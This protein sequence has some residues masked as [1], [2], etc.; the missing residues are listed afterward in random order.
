LGPLE[1]AAYPIA[2][3]LILC[4]ELQEWNREAYGIL[5]KKR[6]QAAQAKLAVTDDALDIT[7]ITREGSLPPDF[8]REKKKL[9]RRLLAL[10][11]LFGTV[12]VHCKAPNRT[13]LPQT[14]NAPAPRPSLPELEGLARAIHEL[15]N[16]K[17]LLRSPDK[18]LKYPDFDSLPDTL[19][20]SNLRQAMDIPEKLRKMGFLMG[21]T[22]APGMRVDTIPEEYV[23]YL[24]KEE[25]EAWVEERRSTGWVL[26]DHVDAQNKI[27]PYLIPYERLPEE[28][29]QLDRDPVQNIPLLLSK[30]GLA[31]YGKGE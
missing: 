8:S 19:K 21:R 10:D 16:E 30:L 14:D 28:I 3:L 11:A 25:H 12:S 27:T 23:E 18:P 31:V 1:P 13:P 5:D 4:D 15:Y 7:L 20:Y 26:G 2:Y 17:Q 24:A 6:A 9:L 22:E 29:K